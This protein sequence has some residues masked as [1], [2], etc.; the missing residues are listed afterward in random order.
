MTTRA[1]E[2][3]EDEHAEITNLIS[4]MNAD[5]CQ[6]EQEGIDRWEFILT[7]MSKFDKERASN[8]RE[9]LEGDWEED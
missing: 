7:L 4:D 9:S 8:W 5:T 6:T 1:I 3:T 2:L